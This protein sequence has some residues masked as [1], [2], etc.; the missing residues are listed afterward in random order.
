MNTPLENSN[1][2]GHSESPQ[3]N[4]A[5]GYNPAPAPQPQP[6]PQPEAADSAERAGA[7][8]SDRRQARAIKAYL[9]ALQSRRPGRPVTRKSL[10]ER[11]GRLTEKIESTDDPLGS[12]ELLQ[13]RLDLERSLAEFDE[14]S[15]FDML[16]AGFVQ[17]AKP[18]SERKGITYTAWR[19]I[20]V[21]AAVLKAA[22]IPETRRR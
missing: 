7:P 20:G 9:N 16:Q 2:A 14:R 3:H 21:P 8:V 5:P 10:E 22:G 15:D 6:G 12:V 18:Y 11:L 4:P 13:K 19:Q 1:P 17:N